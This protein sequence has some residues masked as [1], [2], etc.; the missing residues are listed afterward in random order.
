MIYV[1]LPLCELRIICKFGI[2]SFKKK[3]FHA[4]IINHIPLVHVK[5]IR[6]FGENEILLLDVILYENLIVNPT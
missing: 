5:A 4:F 2:F 6:T 1:C 3:R